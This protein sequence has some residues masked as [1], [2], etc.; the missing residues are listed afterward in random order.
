MPHDPL[1]SCKPTM[2]R[3]HFSSRQSYDC[4]YQ[5]YILI[6]KKNTFIPNPARGLQPPAS[7]WE[8]SSWI[9]QTFL[10]PTTWPSLQG[11]YSS[12][13][14]PGV[15]R[16]CSRGISSTWQ[17]LKYFGSSNNKR[18]TR[19]ESC[20]ARQLYEYSFY[21]S[22]KYRNF[23]SWR[24][25]SRNADKMEQALELDNVLKC[26]LVLKHSHSSRHTGTELDCFQ[27]AGSSHHDYQRHLELIAQNSIMWTECSGLTLL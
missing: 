20:A 13:T 22:C 25:E 26:H 10:K 19:L 21:P 6:M 18:K 8:G 14:S 2:G 17:K 1:L 5:V 23:C 3:G 9:C 12:S 24:N 15:H 27:L 4:S 11:R 7:I 16:S